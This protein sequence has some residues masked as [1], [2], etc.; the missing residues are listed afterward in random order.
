M[1]TRVALIGAGGH[2][3][4]HRRT[5]Q[6]LSD[7]GTVEVAGLCDRQPV[8]PHPDAPLPGVPFYRDHRELLAGERPE[9][10]IVCTPP[11]THLAI[12]L[13]VLAVGADLLLEKPPVMSSFEHDR[14]AE[15]VA[16]S[17]RLCQVGFQALGSTAL[18]ELCAA[19]PAGPIGVSGAW[20]RPD[21]YYERA[22]WAGR[23]AVD[24][25]PVLDGALVNPF[26]HALM[27]ALVLADEG[28]PGFRPV[29]ME[30]ERYRTRPI[31]T[32]DTTFL[33]LTGNDGRRVTVGV[34]LASAVFIA[35][36]IR[37][38]G[39]VLEYPTDRL[40]L[41]G[42]AEVQRVPGRTGLLENLIEHRRDPRTPLLAPLARTGL[43]TAVAEAIVRAPE[44][45][46]IGDGWL[47]PHPDGGGRVV[48]G[49]D[50]IVREVA[51]TDRLPSETRVPWAAEV[52]R[53]VVEPRLRLGAAQPVRQ[54]D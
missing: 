38:G 5:L 37:A 29:R 40:R 28:G 15:A 6:R 13:D 49:I 52:H 10:V 48:T 51:E 54:R 12:A 32:D 21:S 2:G 19:A 16:E 26:A 24:G 53:T 23:R 50:E 35:G 41:S 39:A 33:R 30:L 45:S 46:V 14:L 36:E 27:Q 43:F 4:S 17:G 8:D 34:T 9:I 31:E 11:H 42:Q 44:P 25:R 1:A 7:A 20:W 47:A 22:P 18:A 3:L